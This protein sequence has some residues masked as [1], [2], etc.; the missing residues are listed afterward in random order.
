MTPPRSLTAAAN[1][2]EASRRLPTN[3][4][5]RTNFFGKVLYTARSAEFRTEDGVL[6]A[7]ENCEKHGLEGLVVIGGDG[8]FR[9]A[10]DLSA[11]GIACVGL[12]GTIDNDIACTEYNND[13]GGKQ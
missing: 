7:K 12:P 9:G 1:G 11:H 10:A 4:P 6:L 8:S 5:I 13:H 2:P 3:Q